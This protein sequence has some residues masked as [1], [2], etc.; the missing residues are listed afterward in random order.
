MEKQNDIALKYRNN[1]K[2]LRNYVKS[3]TNT[4]TWLVTLLQLKTQR[5]RFYTK[6][7]ILTF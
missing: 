5:K 2:R 6:E 1:P 4:A 3:K 7:K